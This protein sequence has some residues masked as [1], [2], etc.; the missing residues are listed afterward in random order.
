MPAFTLHRNFVLR[1]TRGHT[2]RF[3][4]EVPAHV[5]T[6]C[7]S[8]AIAIG[9]VSVDGSANVLGDEKEVEIPL[10]PDQRKAKVFEAFSQMVQRNDRLDFTASGVPNAKRVTPLCGF[11]LTS[12]DRDTYWTEFKAGL[13]EDKDQ[14]ILDSQTDAKSES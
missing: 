13:Q 8:D 6:A 7:I 4:K 14:A 11:E 1:T 2:I 3:E 10:T 9:A 5:P 12:R